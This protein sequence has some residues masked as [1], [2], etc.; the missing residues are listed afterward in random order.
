MNLHVSLI[1]LAVLALA[2]ACAGTNS[3]LASS[4]PAE[5]YRAIRAA[6]RAGDWG[7]VYDSLTPDSQYIWGARAALKS[8]EARDSVFGAPIS[9]AE[10]RAAFITSME[11]N[12]TSK[13]WPEIEITDTVVEGD[14]ATLSSDATE[15]KA[16]MVKVDGI[17]KL[18]LGLFGP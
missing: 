10:K 1:V 4:D 6:G 15:E 8:R 18:K 5:A 17:W 7:T 11:N 2:G 13:D 14:T 12:P 3:G 9:D 16:T